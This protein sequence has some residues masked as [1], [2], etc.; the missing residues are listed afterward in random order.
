MNSHD[1]CELAW[2]A[3]VARAAGKPGKADAL[4]RELS[5]E[6]VADY[7]AWVGSE[8]ER[9]IAEHHRRRPRFPRQ[10]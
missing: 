2:K 1:R 7:D 9:Q 6:M 8:M 5:Q 3:D 4:E 10:P